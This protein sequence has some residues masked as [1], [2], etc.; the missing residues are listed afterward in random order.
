[1]SDEAGQLSRLI[2]EIYDAALDRSL[3]YSVLQH[4]CEYV[5]G[6]TSALMSHDVHQQSANF[7]FT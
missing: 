2:S 5:G 3:W 4:T 1:M 7:Y 6:R